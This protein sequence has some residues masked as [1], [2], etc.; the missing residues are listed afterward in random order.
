MMD[1][2]ILLCTETI[3]AIEAIE[4]TTQ[5]IMDWNIVLSTFLGALFGAVCSYP[6]I[7]WSNNSL[8]KSAVKKLTTRIKNEL[9]TNR[10]NLEKV[11]DDPT[12]I[13]VFSSPLWEIVPSDLLLYF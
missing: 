11:K 2:N 8:K 13:W 9:K 4:V 12:K 7:L 10:D 5:G 3:G 1:C 6:I